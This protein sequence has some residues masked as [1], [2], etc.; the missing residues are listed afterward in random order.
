MSAQ[1]SP[2]EAYTLVLNRNWLAIGVTTVRHALSLVFGG[3]AR[4]LHPDTFEVHDFDSWSDLRLTDG[5]PCVR[6]VSLRIKVPEIIVLPV[7][8]G[9]SDYLK[10]VRESTI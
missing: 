1:N 4:A 8:D 10:W 6:T 2:L 7:L 3:A 5:E 9:S